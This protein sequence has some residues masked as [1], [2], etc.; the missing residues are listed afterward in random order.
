MIL[1]CQGCTDR[2]QTRAEGRF[3]TGFPK[4]YPILDAGYLPVE[5]RADFLARLVRELADAGVGIL[6]YR[7]KKG[8]AAEVLADARVMR[9]AV[10]ERLR[11]VM[12]DWPRLAVEA[13]FDGVHVGQMD[14]SPGRARAI[15]GPERM[16]GVSTHSEVQMLAADAEPVDYIA[17]GPV[18]ATAT[19]ENP[20]PVV[21]LDGVRMAR[22]L[23]RKPLVAIGG[24][25][26]GNA[27]DV[28]AAGA[29]SVAVISAVFGSGGDV[30]SRAREFLR[31]ASQRNVRSV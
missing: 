1:H 8:G 16:V 10:G 19:K 25:T 22:W 28:W 23:T 21:G 26:A 2:L 9:V 11:L 15:V 6:Q 31:Q 13:G 27:G 20:D 18:H 30:A 7:N 3:V 5:G 4:L 17:I 12:N 24:I 14:I 29:D